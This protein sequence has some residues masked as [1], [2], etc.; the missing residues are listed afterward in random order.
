MTILKCPYL[1]ADLAF[2]FKGIQDLLT[3]IV[4]LFLEPLN[5]SEHLSRPIVLFN[6]RLVLVN[7]H[8]NG[9]E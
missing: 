9:L 1:S 4:T 8:R 6:Y 7:D 2:F 3:T 5:D